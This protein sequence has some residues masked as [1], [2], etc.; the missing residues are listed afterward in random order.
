[1]EEKKGFIVPEIE[2][3]RFETSDVIT[4]SEGLD[5]PDDEWE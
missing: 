2:I 1:M 3:V 4:T 5:L